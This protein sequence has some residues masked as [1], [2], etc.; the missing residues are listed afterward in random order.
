MGLFAIA[1]IAVC[2]GTIAIFVIIIV[3]SLLVPALTRLIKYIKSN[4]A[5]N[6]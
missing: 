6:H 1:V 3:V 5:K 2:V 4:Y